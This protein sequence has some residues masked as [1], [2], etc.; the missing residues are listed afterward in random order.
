ML[1]GGN[2]DHRRHQRLGQVGKAA[3]R[4]GHGH[5]VADLQVFVLG[6]L[7]S[8]RIAGHEGDG[9]PANEQSRGDRIG[10]SHCL[11]VLVHPLG[12]ANR[13]KMRGG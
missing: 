9:C 3:G 4:T 6:H 8:G 11:H 10:V 7:G 5:C 12:R 13:A 2:V 1:A